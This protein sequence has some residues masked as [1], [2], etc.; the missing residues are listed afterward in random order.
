MTYSKETYRWKKEHGICVDCGCEEAVGGVRCPECAAKKAESAMQKHCNMSH[1]EKEE[2]N[3]K[4]REKAKALRKYRKEH[5]LCL[6]CGKPVYNGH[7]YCM[8]HFLYH[9]RYK[10]KKQAESNKGYRELGLCRICGKEVVSGKKLC[11]EHLKQY[12]EI[13]QKNSYTL[14]RRKNER[15]Q[16]RKN[17]SGM[18]R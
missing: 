8:E 3:K 7:A 17:V 15:T 13:M 4:R 2:H 5:G 18:S 9:K 6:Q 10:K 16:Q 1:E 11:A 12:Q 14:N